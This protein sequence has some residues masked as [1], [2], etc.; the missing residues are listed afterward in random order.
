[1]HLMKDEEVKIM[2]LYKEKSQKLLKKYQF[3]MIK[4]IVKK[5]ILNIKMY[6]KIKYISKNSIHESLMEKVCTIL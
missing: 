3:M 4:P 5:N 2:N 6:K 1:M